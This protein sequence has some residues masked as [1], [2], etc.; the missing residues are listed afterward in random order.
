MSIEEG[1]DMFC[2]GIQVAGPFW[3]HVLGYWKMSLKYPER[4]LFLKYEDLKEDFTSNLKK[5]ADFLNYPFSDDEI[6]QGVVEEISMLCSFENLKN[7]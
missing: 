2:N 1:F 5:I 6:E 4:V 7:L 3:E